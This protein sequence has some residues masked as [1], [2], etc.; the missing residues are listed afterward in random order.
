[1][2]PVTLQAFVDELEKTAFTW[3]TPD[4][5]KDW[6]KHEKELEVARRKA[7]AI[8]QSLANKYN[9]SPYLA[10]SLATGLNK[11]GDFDFDFAIRVTSENKF[12]DLAKRLGNTLE[13]SPYNKPGTDYRVFKTKAL[14]EDVDVALIYGDK[15]KIQ[16]EAIKDVAEKLT[17]AERLKLVQKKVDLDNA[18][19]FKEQRYH[20]FKRDLDQKLGLPRF[21]RDPL[22]KTARVATPEEIKQ[23]TRADVFGH[24]TNHL[25]PIV[26]SGKLLSAAELA[27]KGVIKSY[28]T[29]NPLN[30]FGARM[31]STEIPKELRSEVFITKGLVPASSSY[32]QYGVLFRKRNTEP[33]RY[34]NMVPEEYVTNFVGSKMTFVVPD[35]E[36]QD[37]SKRHPKKTFIGESSVPDSKRLETRS[38]LALL[39]R[40]KNGP[41]LTQK[42]EQVR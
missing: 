38:V 17:P 9:V 34:L 16:R 25:E 18:W 42:T 10:G 4:V 37:W 30:P 8:R 12:K 13:G 26:S 1:M 19:F 33:S 23:F 29:A 32:G 41:Q 36:L 28:E 2:R 22:K 27:R 14:G 11:P 35:A 7:E 39:T 6:D 21:T 5:K 31:R 40:I 3:R 15:A 20:E 24:R